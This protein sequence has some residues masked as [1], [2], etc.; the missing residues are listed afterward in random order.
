MTKTT[1]YQLNQWE[2]T[3]RVLREDFN[4][5]NRKIEEA[6]DQLKNQRS[7]DLLY[8][9]TA[10]NSAESIVC[11][12]DINWNDWKT[13]HVQCNALTNE[14]R[15]E[16]LVSLGNATIMKAWGNLKNAKR[17]YLGYAILFSW[18]NARRNIACFYTN[19]YT[20]TNWL[21]ESLRYFDSEQQQFELSVYS[22]KLLAGT[23]LTVWGEH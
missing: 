4:A 21:M 17:P 5:D 15:T 18:N 3:D 14:D 2:P 23:T 10:E 11:P 16:V 12:V 20:G 13:V 9:Y 19:G 1:N 22:G 7:L 6:L 8:T